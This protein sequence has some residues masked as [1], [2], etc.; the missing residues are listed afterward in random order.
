MN[1][2]VENFFSEVNIADPNNLIAYTRN[3]I[4]VLLGDTGNLQNKLLPAESLLVVLNNQKSVDY[5][6]LRSAQAPAVQYKQSS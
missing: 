1:L 6:D 3:G 5:I 2:N 4:P